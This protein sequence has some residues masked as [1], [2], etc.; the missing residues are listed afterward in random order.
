MPHKIQVILI[1]YGAIFLTLAICYC[2]LKQTYKWIIESLHNV[3][4]WD[5]LT[6]KHNWLATI[7]KVVESI[8]FI[9]IGILIALPINCIIAYI[10]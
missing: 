8:A 9:V 3:E 10:E 1:S 6:R 7:D 2:M 5:T 4:D